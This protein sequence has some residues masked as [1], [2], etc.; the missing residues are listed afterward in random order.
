MTSQNAILSCL[1]GDLFVEPNLI[2]EEVMTTSSLK[3]LFRATM[4]D[5]SN[6]PTLRDRLA[7]LF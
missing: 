3:A 2:I 5:F 6:Y 7:E 1:A 4:E